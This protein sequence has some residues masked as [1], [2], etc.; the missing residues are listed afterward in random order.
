M[1]EREQTDRPTTNFTEAVDGL[2]HELRQL[3]ALHP[4]ELA[5]RYF[6]NNP[7]TIVPLALALATITDSAQVAILL[8]TNTGGDSDSVASIAGG[9]AGARYPDSVN[10]E[11]SAAMQTVNGHNLVSIA[12]AL[13]SLRR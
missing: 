4:A 1:A 12:E 9:I 10:A 5:A 13:T 2:F 3:R 11:W 6:P 7:L 8:A